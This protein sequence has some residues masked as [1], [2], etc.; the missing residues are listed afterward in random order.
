EQIDVCGGLAGT[1]NVTITASLP[2]ALGGARASARVLVV[3]PLPSIGS[4]FPSSV[5]AASSGFELA[6]Y[7][8]GSPYTLVGPPTVYWN[9]PPRTARFGLWDICPGICPPAPLVATIPASDVATPG[10]ATITVV[11]PGPGGGTSNPVTFTI[12][13]PQQAAEIPTLSDWAL[14]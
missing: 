6:I 7:D 1:E 12:T 8:G 11:N 10:T 4:I 2:V 3:N 9:G 5:A 14:L 13:A